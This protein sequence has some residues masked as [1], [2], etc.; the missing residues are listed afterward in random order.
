MSCDRMML[1]SDFMY[2][3]KRVWL[4]DDPCGTPHI[5]FLAS[6]VKGGSLILWIFL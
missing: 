1:T 3:L 4:R 2:I 5:N 6:D